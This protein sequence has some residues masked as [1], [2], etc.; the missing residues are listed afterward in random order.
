MLKRDNTEFLEERGVD[1]QLFNI[2][3]IKED[4][5]LCEGGAISVYFV[6][7]GA[8]LLSQFRLFATSW[9]VACQA[10]VLM[11]FSRQEYWSG[12]PFPAPGDLPNQGIKPLSLVSCIGR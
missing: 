2:S 10:P 4:C 5:R 1:C 8:Q 7:V 3:K 6:S 11:D 12:L 9:I